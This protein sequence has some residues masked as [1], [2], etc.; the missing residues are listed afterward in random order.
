L[1][2]FGYLKKKSAKSCATGEHS[3]NLVTLKA[4]EGPAMIG[5][6]VQPLKK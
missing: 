5:T 2:Y 3:P 6:V 1:G 4:T